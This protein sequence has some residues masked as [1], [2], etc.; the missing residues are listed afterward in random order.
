MGPAWRSEP[1]SDC[2]INW[3]PGS[4]RHRC[5][6]H[7]RRRCFR[8]AARAR[9]APS[10]LSLPLTAPLRSI[11][12]YVLAP[13][14]WK[15]S[16]VATGCIRTMRWRLA[17]VGVAAPRSISTP[18]FLPRLRTSPTRRASCQERPLTWAK[19]STRGWTPPP[20]LPRTPGRPRRRCSGHS[21]HRASLAPLRNSSSRRPN[22]RDAQCRRLRRRGTSAPRSF[23]WRS[24]ELGAAPWTARSTPP[25]LSRFPSVPPARCL[26]AALC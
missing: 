12:G 21:R 7:A 24:A 16:P 4:S 25:P 23:P 8:Q 17:C 2:C 10:L 9:A 22:Q 13:R 5:A 11:P 1:T 6:N 20:S 14:F 26:Q 3:R 18:S 15:R 19:L